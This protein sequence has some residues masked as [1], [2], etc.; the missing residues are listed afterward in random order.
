M[1]LR[2][3][4]FKI[5]GEQGIGPDITGNS[6]GGSQF[7]FFTTGKNFRIQP[8]GGIEFRGF[9]GLNIVTDGNLFVGEKVV[10]ETEGECEYGFSIFSGKKHL[11]NEYGGGL[12][13]VYKPL[14]INP[15]SSRSALGE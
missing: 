10:V 4:L 3:G 6:L 7:F 14:V 8:Y 9:R 15:L 2:L 12:G 1:L 13:P 11:V 5:L